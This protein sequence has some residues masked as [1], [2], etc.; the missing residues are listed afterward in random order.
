MTYSIVG[1][2]NMA[3]FLATRLTLAKH[4]CVGIYGRNDDTTAA[5][6]ARFGIPQISDIS[7]IS[8]LE[9][10]VCFLAVADDTI[11]E[12]TPQLQMGN[13][14]L[15]H[16]SGTTPLAYLQQHT[17]NV[18]V[19][20]PVYSIAQQSLP[21]HRA[22]PCAWDAS[23]TEKATSTVLH[24]VNSI[25]D[26]A[27]QAND[28]QRAWLHLTAV[29]GN[30]FTNHL[31][32]ICEAICAEQQLPFDTLLPIL[33]QTF[34]RV[35]QHSPATLQTGPAARGDAHTMQKQEAMLADHPLW[36]Q[37]Y[38]ALSASIIAKEAG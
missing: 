16:T 6:S 8:T 36:Q 34:E 33:Q 11:K 23:G 13:T 14:V 26:T 9:A 15:V 10:D 3:W 22:I 2:G 32:A 38:K 27:F 37:V 7:T 1:S 29:L 21:M 5:I 12:L 31:M 28:T 17:T 19:I 35:S 18:G 25:T 30:N 24:V 20:W 4:S